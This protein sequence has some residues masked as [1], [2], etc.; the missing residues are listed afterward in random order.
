MVLCISC[1][2][3]EGSIELA[4]VVTTKIQDSNIPRTNM[5][6]TS[7][8]EGCSVFFKDFIKFEKAVLEGTGFT[9]FI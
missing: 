3:L 6:M 8:L 5:F 1:L 4:R 2:D 7:T 9:V